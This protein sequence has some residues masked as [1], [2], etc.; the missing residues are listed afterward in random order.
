MHRHSCITHNRYS[1]AQAIPTAVSAIR[2]MRGGSRSLLVAD[3]TGQ[4]WVLKCR[5]NPQHDKV[6]LN[7]FLGNCIAQDIG[8]S[9]PPFSLMRTSES[10]GS[11]LQFAP[12]RGQENIHHIHFASAFVGS[13]K[14]GHD[15]EG[16]PPNYPHSIAN[17]HEFAGVLALDLWLDNT[18]RRQ[19]IFA[20]RA[21]SRK[22]T[23]F[24]IDFGSCFGRDNWLLAPLGSPRLF[25][26]RAVYDAIRSL[27][28][29]EPWLSKIEGFSI[30]R[31]RQ[32]ADQMPGEWRLGNEESLKGLLFDLT[33]RQQSLRR[34]LSSFIERRQDIFSGWR[35]SMRSANTVD[36]FLPPAHDDAIMDWPDAI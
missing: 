21:R 31:L 20:R 18:D 27:A 34:S 9:V 24:W 10:I 14:P 33:L 13:L 1:L 7:E 16:L 11:K 22:Y 32:I 23:A 3:A 12:G 36:H 15:L 19:A 4:P 28:D 8:L 25:R 2:Y 6:A 17:M 35:G 5:D 26:D 29:F 30:D